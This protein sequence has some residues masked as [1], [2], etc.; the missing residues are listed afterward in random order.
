[1]GTMTAE[2]LKRSTVLCVHFVQPSGLPL[3]RDLAQHSLFV[4]E[5]DGATIRVKQELFSAMAKALRFPDWFGANWD[6]LNDCLRDLEWL[7]G[8][9][10]VL[11][12]RNATELWRA[13]TS[14]AGGLVETWLVCAEFWMEQD[15]PFHL[16]FLVDDDS[17]M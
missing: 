13:A 15:F 2:D 10:C 1:M 16:V 8:E 11:I 9:G 5:I 17:T 4:G 3:T 14:L 12:V 7:P 6:A